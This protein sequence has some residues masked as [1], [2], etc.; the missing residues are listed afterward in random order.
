MFNG[1]RIGYHTPLPLPHHG[2]QYMLCIEVIRQQLCCV[3]I[4]ESRIKCD[5]EHV[6]AH[7]IYHPEC[8]CVTNLFYINRI[9]QGSV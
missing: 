2:L 6:N 9:R 3:H 4:F 8:Y 7:E 1:T 5:L